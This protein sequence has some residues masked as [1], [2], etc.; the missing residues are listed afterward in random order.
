MVKAVD[1]VSLELLK[2]ETLGLVGESGCGKTTLS[3]LI[4][5]LIKPDE[6]EIIYQDKDISN[7]GFYKKVQI[8][9]Q[10]PYSSLNPRMKIKEIL[11]EPLVVHK[12]Y[13]KKTINNELA[14][15]LE[16][17]GLE[18]SA[19]SRL[20]H[21]FSGGQRQ[22]IV[23]ARALM[24]N[25]EVLVCD[26]PVSALDLSIQARILNLLLDLQKAHNLSMIFISHDQA[27]VKRMSDR[28]ITM[29]QGKIIL[30]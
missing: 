12:K 13:N 24:L 18:N 6:G 19:L 23:I 20:P 9:F 28:I 11:S 22:R 15:R 3:R 26:E 27:V 21:Q 4:M 7:K 17:V 29:H 30:A 10:D 14:Q 1:G 5:K 16:E 8:V 2:G 25:P